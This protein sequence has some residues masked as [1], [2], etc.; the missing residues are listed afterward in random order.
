VTYNDIKDYGLTFL[1]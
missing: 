1:A